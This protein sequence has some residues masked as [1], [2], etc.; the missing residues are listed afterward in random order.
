MLQQT[1]LEDTN[2]QIDELQNLFH[3]I[4]VYEKQ[5]ADQCHLLE[6]NDRTIKTLQSDLSE[7]VQKL[8]ILEAQKNELSIQT[9]NNVTESNA[10]TDAV[11]STVELEMTISSL[12][13]QIAGNI[14]STTNYYSEFCS[15][16]YH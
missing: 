16:Y 1:G 10:V 7:N 5:I 6:A 2:S 13:E 4:S 12:K 8:V 9:V 15:Y 11:S 3:K 14:I